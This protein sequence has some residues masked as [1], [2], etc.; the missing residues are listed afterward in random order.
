MKI[1]KREIMFSVDNEITI[2]VRLKF[3][4]FPQLFHGWGQIVTSLVSLT[5]V[6]HIQAISTP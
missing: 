2:P 5:G 3:P 4:L 6:L 1:H